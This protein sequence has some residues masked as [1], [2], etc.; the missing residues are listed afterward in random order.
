MASHR[1]GGAGGDEIRFAE[2]EKG[3]VSTEDD[4]NTPLGQVM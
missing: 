2:A 1:E 4:P 3:A